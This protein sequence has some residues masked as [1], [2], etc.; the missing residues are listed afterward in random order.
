MLM[1]VMRS[2]NPPVWNVVLHYLKSNNTKTNMVLKIGIEA[3][4]LPTTLLEHI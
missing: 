2:G 1:G 4:K 3:I